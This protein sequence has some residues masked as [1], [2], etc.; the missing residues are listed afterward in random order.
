MY[1]QIIGFTRSVIRKIIKLFIL[2]FP[3]WKNLAQFYCPNPKTSIQRLLNAILYAPIWKLVFYHMYDEKCRD[4]MFE[5]IYSYY[6]NYKFKEGDIILQVGANRGLATNRFLRAIGK[7][8][9]LIAIEADCDNLSA[10]EKRM[11]MDNRQNITII[12]FGAWSKKCE[13]R[14]LTKG[15]KEHR[16]AE[17]P[18]HDVR[19]QDITGAEVDI[20]EDH[21]DKAT[22]IPVDTVDNILKNNNIAYNVINYALIETNGAEYEVLKGMEETLKKVEEL[23][24]RAHVELDGIAINKNIT[25]LLNKK[26]F[27]TLVNIEGDV[28]ASKITRFKTS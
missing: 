17:L 26:G 22:V 2:L 25:S 27:N 19:Y 8:G 21:Y 15:S 7:T 20:N 1:K 18:A 4:K 16:I 12:H 5:F 10:L 23:E 11:K 6:F 9:H 28:R 24:L 14:F 13:L 3:Y